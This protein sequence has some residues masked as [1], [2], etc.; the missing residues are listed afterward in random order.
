[1]VRAPDH[2]IAMKLAV[3]IAVFLWVLCGVIGAWML[4]DLDMDH[5][6]V[7]AKGPITLAKAMNEHPVAIPTQ[8]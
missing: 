5:G 7:I 3:G 6:N 4:D 2:G 1:M 8:N